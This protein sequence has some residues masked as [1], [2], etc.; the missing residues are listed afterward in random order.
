VQDGETTE[1]PRL[2][3]IVV[4]G[5]LAAVGVFGLVPAFGRVNQDFGSLYVA[6]RT[7]L[8]QRHFDRVYEE[9]WFRAQ[10]APWPE[11][12]LV[13]FLPH[14]PANAA[15]LT[16]VCMLTPSAAKVIWTLALV[17]A[18]VASVIALQKLTNQSAYWAVLVV[19]LPTAAVSNA[20]A[21]GQPYPLLLL[22]VT[23]ALVA[24]EKG[25]AFTAGAL[26][27]PVVILK[28]Y[29]LPYLAWF[30]WTRRWRAVAGFTAGVVG[31]TAASIAWLGLA[32][33][34]T[35]LEEVLPWALRGEIQDPY[36]P[37]WGSVTSLAYR[38]FRFEPDLNPSPLADLPVV[39][40]IL[41]RGVPLAIL[42][43]AVLVRRSTE[44]RVVRQ[45][46]AALA[47][48]SLAAAPLTASYHFVLL[49]L[50]VALLVTERIGR[51][52]W[53][54][55]LALAF[56]GSSLPHYGMRFV[57]GWTTPL[58]YSRLAVL[59]ALLALVVAPFGRLRVWAIAATLGAGLGAINVKT[60]PNGSWERLSHGFAAASPVDCGDEIGWAAI[61]GVRMVAE[62]SQG[63]R[64]RGAIP[65]ASVGCQ[66]GRV[67]AAPPASPLIKQAP[68]ECASSGRLE[69]LR[70]S[71][72]LRF[73]VGQSWVR[74]S[75]DVLVLDST[76]CLTALLAGGPSNEREPAW[77]ADGRSVLFV[78]DRQR[79][80]GSTAVYRVPFTPPS[81]FD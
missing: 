78:S 74:G 20:L 61:R 26:L 36:S 18:L 33:H 45:Q 24:L 32:V 27:A 72:N 60:A 70:R 44:I 8:D 35:Y 59:V 39:A 16:P 23:L 50:P 2:L 55:L 68:P 3:K 75:W 49:S 31:L 12:G 57:G 17:A 30:V 34:R 48:A 1:P 19:L 5:L 56:V 14:P 71:P 25:R 63:R 52:P 77:T 4:I 64:V 7:A 62:S 66:G 11:L 37:I 53:L 29:A 22:L 51:W 38:L 9:D 80:L 15:L 65:A 42:L 6:A 67:V 69:R 47:I 41:A 21:Y 54:Y 10:S 28:L 43:A 40:A 46:W 79:G 76:T 81:G 58:A 73:F 13:T